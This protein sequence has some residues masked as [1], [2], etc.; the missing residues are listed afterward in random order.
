MKIRTYQKADFD[1]VRSFGS[2]AKY[3]FEFPN[4]EDCRVVI[5]E[6]LLDESGTVRMAAFGRLQANAYLLVDGTWKSPEERLEAIE[7]L[8]FAMV[9]K[10]KL[11]G[12]DQATAQVDPRFGKRLEAFGWHQG[13]GTTFSKEF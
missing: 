8:E 2:E 13:I 5:K 10:A 9:E 7:I 11:L 6:C 4:P 1:R 12:L 3:G